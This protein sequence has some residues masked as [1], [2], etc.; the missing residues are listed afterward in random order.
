MKE[1]T[2]TRQTNPQKVKPLKRSLMIASGTLLLALGLAACEPQGQGQGQ[3]GQGPVGQVDKTME[4]AK[5]ASKEAIQK[6]KKTGKE[7]MKQPGA[8]Q[9]K[10]TTGSGAQGAKAGQKQKAPQP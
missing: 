8:V 1:I 6:A 4:K 9:K 3:Q 2:D 7:V 10:A 5:K